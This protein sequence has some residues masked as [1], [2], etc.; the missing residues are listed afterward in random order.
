MPCYKY[1]GQQQ[2]HLPRF[3]E[4][5]KQ[6]VGMGREVLISHT[7]KQHK[8]VK[9]TLKEKITRNIF[10]GTNPVWSIREDFLNQAIQLS[11]ISSRELT[12][13]Y[14]WECYILDLKIQFCCLV[15]HMFNLCMKVVRNTHISGRHWRERRKEKRETV[16]EPSGKLVMKTPSY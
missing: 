6:V 4:I 12:N 3:H 2:R 10:K 5:Y 1:S 13:V 9:I 15:P 16:Q 14:N 8:T 7:H 11:S